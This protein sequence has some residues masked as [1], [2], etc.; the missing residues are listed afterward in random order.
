MNTNFVIWGVLL[1]LILYLTIRIFA[2]K[3]D[4]SGKAAETTDIPAEN[5]GI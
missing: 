3:N 5:R 1:V 4:K 2:R